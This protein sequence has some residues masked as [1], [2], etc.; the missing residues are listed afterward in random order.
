M[1]N[2]KF[3]IDQNDMPVGFTVSGHAG[4]ADFGKDIVCASVSSAVMLTVN[5]A[6]QNFNISADLNVGDNVVSCKF[7][8]SSSDGAKLLLGLKAHFD[9]LSEDYPKSIKVNISEV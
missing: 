1:I 5:T 3:F 8:E 6:M 4:Y 9:A 7:K 2:V